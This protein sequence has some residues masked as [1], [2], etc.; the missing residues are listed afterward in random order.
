MTSRF[1]IAF[2]T[3]TRWQLAIAMATSESRGSSRSGPDPMTAFPP[4]RRRDRRGARLRHATNRMAGAPPSGRLD[5]CGKVAAP[6][7]AR[8]VADAALWCW[9]ECLSR[10]CIWPHV[11]PRRSC[12]ATGG[13]M[14]GDLSD[15]RRSAFCS[16]YLRHLMSVCSPVS[17]ISIFSCEPSV[18]TSPRSARSLIDISSSRPSSRTRA[19]SMNRTGSSEAHRSASPCQPPSRYRPPRRRIRLV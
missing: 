18:P 10:W 6:P 2:L 17:T 5:P 15:A 12:S 8:S 19:F 4:A 1:A 7:S 13:G 9:L 11:R 16:G 14:R 3:R